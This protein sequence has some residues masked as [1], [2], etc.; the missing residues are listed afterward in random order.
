MLV[1]Q[2]EIGGLLADLDRHSLVPSAGVVRA[3]ARAGTPRPKAPD[4]PCEGTGYAVR[5]TGYAQSATSRARAR[6]P[7]RAAA[8]CP[9]QP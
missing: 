3:G 4:M 5:G 9:A 6:T 2:L 8:G 1:L 7:D